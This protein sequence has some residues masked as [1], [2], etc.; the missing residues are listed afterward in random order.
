MKK[1]IRTAIGLTALL[2]LTVTSASAFGLST[3]GIKFGLNLASLSGDES[4]MTLKSK[5]GFA[6]GG[7]VAFNLSS[8]FDLQAEILFSQKGAT[9]DFNEQDVVA[10]YH[11]NFTYIEIPI[12]LKAYIPLQSAVI[13]PVLY[14][15]PFL[16]FKAGAKTKYEITAYGESQSGEEDMIGVKSTDFGGIIGAGVEIKAGTGK[17]GLEA[18]YGFSFATL[19]TE[20]DT[21]KHRVFS[22]L[23]GYSFF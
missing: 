15:G 14:A 18:R 23:L 1:S 10:S 13:R 4:G 16:S 12:L 9:Y 6:A 22:L 8:E 11:F 17:I 19:S 20:G 2:A 7:F 5:M 21:T 3:A